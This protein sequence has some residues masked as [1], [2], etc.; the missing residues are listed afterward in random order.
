MI[1]D[2]Q[3]PNSSSSYND[4]PPH[5]HHHHHQ[6][7]EAEASTSYLASSSAQGTPATATPTNEI[8]YDDPNI[9]PT[10]CASYAALFPVADLPIANISRIMKRSL[11]ENAK[12]AKDAKE[13]VQDCVSELISFI[14]SEASDKC[15][16]EKRKT[17]NGDDILYAMR[18][19]GFDNYEEV[20]KVYLSRYR[21]AQENNPKARKRSM[22][23]KNLDN[24]G[25]EI[26]GEEADE[27]ERGNKV[28][29]L[30]G[31]DDV[32]SGRGVGGETEAGYRY[33]LTHLTQSPQPTS[34]ATAH[35]S[36]GAQ[37]NA[38]SST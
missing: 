25:G 16:G 37:D 2:Y 5:H 26:E 6:I 27:S 20:L 28:E 33:T 17:I 34:T 22:C 30:D 11:P 15:A 19:L 24:E 35:S 12:I 38:S 1:Q 4:H 36:G 18:V 10:Q 7:Q 8:N 31:R 13:C 29:R 23:K 14:T 32:T 3:T 9:D 21:M